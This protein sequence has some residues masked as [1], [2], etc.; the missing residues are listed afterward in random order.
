MEDAATAR[1]AEE[2]GSRRGPAQWHRRWTEGIGVAAMAALFLVN[3]LAGASFKSMVADEPVHLLYGRL[4]LAHHLEKIRGLTDGKGAVPALAAL[5]VDAGRRIEG[6]EGKVDELFWGRLPT[7]GFGV[8]L[9]LALW[10]LARWLAGREAGL[11]AAWFAAWSP[12]LVAHSKWITFDIAATLGFVLGVFAIVA[13][14]A[15]PGL[16]KGA[17][18]CAAL[19]TAQLAKVSNLSLFALFALFVAS[20]LAWRLVRGAP[21]RAVLLDAGRHLAVLAASGVFTVALLNTVYSSWGRWQPLAAAQQ[22]AATEDGAPTPA[23]SGPAATVPLPLPPD[24]VYELVAGMAHNRRGHWAYFHGAHSMKGWLM[25]FPA[26]LLLKTTLPLLLLFGLALFVRVKGWMR[27]GA[28]DAAVAA[29]AAL[30]LAYFMVAIHVDIGVRYVLPV[31]ALGLALAATAIAAARGRRRR[32]VLWAVL[33]LGGWQAVESAMVFPHHL[34]YFN[35]L[36]GG[37]AGGWRWLNDSNVSWGQDAY[38]LES[39]MREQREPVKLN[40]RRPTPGLIVMD[41]NDLTGLTEDDAR[42]SAWLRDN[43]TP[44]GYVTPALAIFRVP[45]D[46]RFRALLERWGS[47]GGAAAR[48]PSMR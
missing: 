34:S 31:Y 16:W 44:V 32:L 47:G 10:G 14:L 27:P 41:V 38:Y 17:A 6:G 25:Y 5:A 11:V 37:P 7:A 9:L 46:A 3:V 23:T 12:N 29:A 18:V 28:R 30:Y 26:A 15:K 35:E 22:A 20:S 40:P 8:A 43:Y 33:L 42:R 24:Y 13:Y 1:N 45:A 39:W 2:G 19:G 36:A 48:Q 21:R 4:F